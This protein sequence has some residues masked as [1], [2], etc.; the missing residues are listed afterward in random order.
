[1][2]KNA[3]LDLQLESNTIREQIEIRKAH[4]INCQM[5]EMMDKPAPAGFRAADP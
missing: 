1:M 5:L 2:A 4:G 3:A